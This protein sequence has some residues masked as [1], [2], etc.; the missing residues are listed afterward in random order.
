MGICKGVWE[1]AGEIAAVYVAE[2][3]R[4][5]R[6]VYFGKMVCRRVVGI[7]L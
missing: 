2:G 4:L 7:F 1:K 5:R 3:S 6:E